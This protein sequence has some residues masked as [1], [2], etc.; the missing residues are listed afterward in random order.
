M[1][2][3]HFPWASFPR[4]MRR[5]LRRVTNGPDAII[6]DNTETRKL[7]PVAVS[8][9]LLADFARA[10]RGYEIEHPPQPCGEGGSAFALASF[11]GRSIL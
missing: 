7:L 11:G 8:D 1:S 6:R 4:S 3:W 2:L 10:Q 5:I 9:C